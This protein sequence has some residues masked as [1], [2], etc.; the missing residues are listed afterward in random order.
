MEIARANVEDAEEI[1]AVQK[2]AYTEEAKL[3]DGFQIPPLLETLNQLRAKFKTH[4][5]LQATAAGKIVGSIRVL[6]KDGTCEVSRLMVHPDYQ[7]R[8]VATKLLLEAENVFPSCRRFELFTGDKSVKNIYL[9][10]KLGYKIFKSEK[11]QGNVT[12]V[13]LEKLR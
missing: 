13:F 8:G 3:Y 10:Q 1:L 2:L 7:N 9:Y 6:Q 4:V 12:L 5:F 11:P